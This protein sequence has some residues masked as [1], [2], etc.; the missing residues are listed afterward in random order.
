MGRRTRRPGWILVA[1]VAIACAAHGA[2]SSAAAPA[3]RAPEPAAGGPGPAAVQPAGLAMVSIGFEYRKP[4]NPAHA[5]LYADM[6]ER[7]F[8]EHLADA[9]APVKLPR[10]LT[11]VFRGCNGTSNA[12][13]GLDDSTITFCYEYLADIHRAV[14][15]NP[16]KDVSLA[17]AIDGPTMFVMLHEAAHAVFQLLQV[18]VL[19]REE[20]AADTFAAVA[21]LR[22]GKVTA[23]R[24]LEGA[25]WGY[26][27]EARTDA[28]DESDF[29][30]THGLDH[31][32]Y[33]NLLC[34]AYG[35]D[36]AYF[37]RVVERGRLPKERAAGCR[38]EYLQARFAIQKLIAPSLEGAPTERIEITHRAR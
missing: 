1:G 18:P 3:A 30:D 34:L 5:Q 31:Q 13:W 7:A 12:Y 38:E 21:L 17:D 23:Y 35:S 9:L 26:G 4:D 14:E 19:G 33:Y 8:L 10:P 29:A 22:M 27:E 6:R 11:L 24:M 36:P 25:A 37:A 28:Y 15:E 20:D 16:P 2:S 32:R